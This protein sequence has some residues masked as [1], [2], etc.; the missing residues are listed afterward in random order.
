MAKKASRRLVQRR[1]VRDL[2]RLARMVPGGSP[3]RPVEIDTP[4]V[5]EVMAVAA[6][7]PLCGGGLRLVEHAAETIDGVRLR[8]ARLACTGCGVA[9]AMYFKL[10]ALQ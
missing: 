7:C 8:V 10:R 1:H 2:D 9:R 6:P 3:E 4:A 5:V